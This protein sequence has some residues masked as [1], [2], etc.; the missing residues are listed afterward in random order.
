MSLTIR[1]SKESDIPSMLEMVSES[2]KTMRDNGNI[3][4][5]SDSYPSSQTMMD[6]INNGV[7]YII[8]DNGQPVGTFAFIEG[9]DITYRKIYNGCWI[10]NTMPYYVIHRIA[11]LQRFHGIFKTMIDYCFSKTNNIRID[12]HHDNKIMI[13]LLKRYEFIYCGI[14]HL[15]NGDERIA[16]QKIKSRD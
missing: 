2:R 14:I 8:E 4:Q 6:D 7:S 13:N 12:T 10:N 16:F 15:L 5:W 11:S 9:P 1:K 3:H